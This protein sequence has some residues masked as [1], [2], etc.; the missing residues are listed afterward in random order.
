MTEKHGHKHHGKSS[1]QILNAMEVL[2]AIKPVIGNIFLDAGCGDGY[3]SIAASNLVGDQGKVYALDVYPESIETVKKEIK[4]RKLENVDAILAD[5]TNTI[6]LDSSSID[7]VLMANVLHGFV[8]GGE[9]GD[10]MSNIVRCLKPGGIFAVVE[11]RKL[12]SNKG[13]PLNVRIS[14]ED[15]SIILKDYGFDVIDN[16]EI[17]NYHYIVKGI[18]KK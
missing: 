8:A 9:V 7:I 5:I 12:E 17:G 2:E 1:R 14:P 6:P 15:V 16:H 4:D 18:K 13:P 10:V 3:I 11:F